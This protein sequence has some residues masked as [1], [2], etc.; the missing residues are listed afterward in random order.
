MIDLGGLV[1]VGEIKTGQV[2]IV[3]GIAWLL[4]V[5]LRSHE[6]ERQGTVTRAGRR[7]EGRPSGDDSGLDQR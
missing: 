4:V 6:E 7:G 5:Q 3:N 1:Q 2:G